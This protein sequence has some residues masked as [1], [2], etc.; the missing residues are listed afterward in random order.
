[1]RVSGHHALTPKKRKLNVY[2][3]PHTRSKLCANECHSRKEVH[4]QQTQEAKKH[5]ENNLDDSLPGS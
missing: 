1:M 5:L 3:I 4:R 2:S